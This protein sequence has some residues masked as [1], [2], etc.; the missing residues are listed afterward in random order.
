VSTAAGDVRIRRFDGPS[1][2]IKS[3]TGDL[4]IG[5]PSGIRVEADIKSMVGRISLP[6][7]VERTDTPSRSVRLRARTT[8]GDI[9]IERA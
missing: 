6:E 2:E 9:R 8:S 5:L 4:Q 3:L 7:P 1:V